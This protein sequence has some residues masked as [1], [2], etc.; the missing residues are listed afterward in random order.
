MKTVRPALRALWLV[1]AISLVGAKTVAQDKKT[2][3]PELSHRASLSEILDWLDKTSFGHARVGLN[4]SG[5]PSVERADGSQDS[6][7]V[8]EKFVFSR[9]FRLANLDGCTLTLRNDDVKLLGYADDALFTIGGGGEH[10]FSEV[11]KT[12][13]RYV[14]ELYVPLHRMSDRKGRA[15]YRHTS[16]AKRAGLLGAWRTTFK[17]KRGRR[18]AGVSIFPAGQREKQGFTDGEM[19]TF[20]FDSKE[21]GEKFNA[22]FRQAIKLCGTK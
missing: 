22:A 4:R 12:P 11:G 7:T 5:D 3:P 19:L 15:A 6:G 13:T 8:G 18:Y 21:A 10:M 2:P 20:T 9:G 17:T 16:D 1:A 14:A